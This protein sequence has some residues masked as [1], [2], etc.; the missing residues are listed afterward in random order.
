[1]E[2]WKQRT[3]LLLGEKKVEQLATASVLIVGLGG[4][5]GI[6]AE[7]LCRA[8]VGRLTLIDPDTVHPT[9]INRQ[10]IALQTTVGQ[11][12]ADVLT[13][14]LLQINPD[15]QP[16][17]INEWLDSENIAKI[18]SCH[19]FDFVADAIDSLSPKVLLIKS[20]L[21]AH[22]PIISSMGA[23]G[24][25]DP[26]KVRIADISTTVHCSL[27]RAVR[28][29]LTKLGIKKGLPTVFS[30]EL[31][32]RRSVVPTDDE[33]FKKSITGTISYLPAIFGCYMASHIIGCLTAI[34]EYKK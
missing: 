9:N 21:E 22:I 14:R 17:T 29:R 25:T 12:K 31:T 16:T 33:R 30:T 28:R 34:N 3:R 7:M 20:C 27:A 8:G 19:P 11:Q 6:T 26:E 15:M 10:I 32:D 5:G 1:M 23:G 24:K 13:Q 2:D 18:L 4:V